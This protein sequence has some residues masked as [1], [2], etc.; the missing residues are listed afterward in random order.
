[1]AIV[2]F[3]E[4]RFDDLGDALRA[5]RTTPD[6]LHCAYTKLLSSNRQPRLLFFARKRFALNVGILERGCFFA[7]SDASL[8]GLCEKTTCLEDGDC[9]VAT[10]TTLQLFEAIGNTVVPF[11]VTDGASGGAN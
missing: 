4:M 8:M 2:H 6:V 11:V 5:F 1:M 7:S 3:V 10:H 9:D